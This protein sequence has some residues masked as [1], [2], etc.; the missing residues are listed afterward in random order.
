MFKKA[1][2]VSVS[3]GLLSAC[4]SNWDV[5][6]TRDLQPQGSPFENA[7]FSGYADLAAQERAEYDWSD[8]AYFVKKA[9]A[10]AGGETVLP[11]ALTA[12][13]LPTDATETV[14]DAHA[15]L[16]EVLDAGARQSMPAQAA[17]AQVAYDCWVQELEENLQPDDIA[18]CKARL[19]AAMKALT[20]QPEPG[21]GG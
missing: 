19:D 4:A 5:E 13:D 17:D 15:A 10:A 11:D 20:A 16:M 12:R 2:L 7:L 8:A 3:A 1:L 18:A 21:G 6:G 9:R 14:A